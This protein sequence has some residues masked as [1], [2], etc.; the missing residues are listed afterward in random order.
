M[1]WRC[2]LRLAARVGIHLDVYTEVGAGGGAHTL[3]LH[4]GLGLC[5]SVTDVTVQHLQALLENILQ[6]VDFIFCLCET[7]NIV[8]KQ[9]L[10][11]NCI[12]QVE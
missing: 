10:I 1:R 5:L 6:L 8:C 7:V 2:C 3:P 11:I 9:L 4:V 12:Q